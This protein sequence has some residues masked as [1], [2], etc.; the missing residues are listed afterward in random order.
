ME[1]WI[2][3]RS[4][5][6]AVAAV[7]VGVGT[8]PSAARADTPRVLYRASAPI[9]D[10]TGGGG[11]S[12]W[13]E[14]LPTCFS[15]WIRTNST[16]KV[17]RF[18]CSS[19]STAGGVDAVS[20]THVY[21]ETTF[22]GQNE[23]GGALF[24]TGEPFTTT[25]VDRFDLLCGAS[26]CA[27]GP[28][29][30]IDDE[31]FAIGD[32]SLVYGVSD[33]SATCPGGAEVF[34]GGRVERIEG[35]APV[36]LD[37]SPGASRIA[38]AG[39]LFAEL[40]HIPN[41]PLQPDIQVRSAVSGALVSTIHPAGDVVGLGMSGAGVGVQVSV[42]GVQ[43]IRLY[44]PATGALEHQV[45]V[46]PSAGMASMSGE[47]ILYAVGSSLRSTELH[48]LNLLTWRTHLLYTLGPRR[49]DPELHLDGRLVS[50]RSGTALMGILL[51][52]LP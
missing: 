13:S 2:G 25:Q 28:L 14:L 48:T 39:N 46:K 38:A 6:T 5:L 41:G 20:S 32:G 9:Q 23:E 36:V 51:P 40:A 33:Y 4:V 18:T 45:W 8:G 44:N 30:S 3:Y 49:T 12:A 26:G 52:P 10:M 47:R 21:W 50:W 7:V 37:S 35:A 42:A 15:I 43:T 17:Q 1:S 16:G 19:P 24:A 11:R 31:G 34:T 27:C 22:L 29:G